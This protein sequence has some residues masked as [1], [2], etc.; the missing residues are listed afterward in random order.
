MT[1]ATMTATQIIATEQSTRG[2]VRSN[3]FSSMG[4]GCD[5]VVVAAKSKEN[6]L[7]Y[8]HS[9][10]NKQVPNQKTNLDYVIKEI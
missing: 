4:R 1:K 5:D 10:T 7:I 2:R 9:F 3:E 8:K 6:I